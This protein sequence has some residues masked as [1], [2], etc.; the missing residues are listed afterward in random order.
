MAQV[1]PIT[2]PEYF[3]SRGYSESPKSQVIKSSVDV[4]PA[5]LRRRYTTD[6]KDIK[7]QMR[8]S[9]DQLDD[10]EVFYFDVLS[11]GV[12]T[13]DLVNPL[14]GVS[15]E[16]RFKEQYQADYEGGVYY[17]VKFDLEIMP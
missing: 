3:D 6:T 11:G 5:K 7:G 1:W 9:Q 17:M 13:F 8:L 16:L 2:L 15:R 12:L 4:G 14:N 10:L